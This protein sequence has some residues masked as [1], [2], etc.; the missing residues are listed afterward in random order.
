MRTS[1]CMLSF[2]KMWTRI[3]T[4]MPWGMLFSY[5]KC[6]LFRLHKAEFNFFEDLHVWKCFSLLPHLI[7]SFA[8]YTTSS[9][10]S[11]V[12]KIL[13]T[14]LHRLLASSIAVR[15]CAAA[16]ISDPLGVTLTPCDN[17]LASCRPSVYLQSSVLRCYT[18][19]AFR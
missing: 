15:S 19:F 4:T 12:F 7:D 10:V 13:T 8:G 16:P 3:I 2:S 5:L 1:L 17:P 14:L 18:Y 11:S 6:I 9:Q